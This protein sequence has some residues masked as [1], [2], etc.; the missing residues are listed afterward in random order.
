VPGHGQG[1]QIYCRQRPYLLVGDERI[2]PKVFLGA[3]AGGGQGQCQ[4]STSGDHLFQS[5]ALKTK[6]LARF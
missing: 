2:A 1:A 6:N 4:K 3:S 5:S